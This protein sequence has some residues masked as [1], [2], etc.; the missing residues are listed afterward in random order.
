VGSPSFYVG[1][2]SSFVGRPSFHD[3]RPTLSEGNIS[4]HEGSPSFKEICTFLP[5]AFP[6]FNETISLNF[7]YSALS[8]EGLA[9]KP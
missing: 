3:G 7:L 6:F 9:N 8:P 2:P 4:S 5:Y 1:C